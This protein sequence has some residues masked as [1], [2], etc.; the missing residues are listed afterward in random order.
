[1]DLRLNRDQHFLYKFI[2]NLNILK[3]IAEKELSNAAQWPGHAG[4]RTWACLAPIFLGKKKI[5][6]MLPNMVDNMSLVMVDN[7]SSSNSYFDHYYSG[8]KIEGIVFLPKKLV[9]QPTSPQKHT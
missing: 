3:K 9:F 8:C 2:S 1:L 4:L 5:G 6:D 7:M